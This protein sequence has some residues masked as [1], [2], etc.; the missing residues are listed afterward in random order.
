VVRRGDRRLFHRPRR[1]RAGAGLASGSTGV[2]RT[3]RLKVGSARG[4]FSR[5]L[6][7]DRGPC[8]KHRPGARNLTKLWP[9]GAADASERREGLRQAQQIR[10]QIRCGASIVSARS[11]HQRS[12]RFPYERAKFRCRNYPTLVPKRHHSSNPYTRWPLPN[13]W[14][15]PDP[16]ASHRHPPSPCCHR[17][18]AQHRGMPADTAPILFG[19]QRSKCRRIC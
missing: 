18:P 5:R 16:R 1:Q 4:T 7:A 3:A 10:A 9:P 19:T 13:R 8:W 14:T 11:K 2:W 6:G 17:P 15:T 12:S